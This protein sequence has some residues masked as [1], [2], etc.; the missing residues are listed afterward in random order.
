MWWGYKSIGFSTETIVQTSPC[1][2]LRADI[3]VQ[4]RAGVAFLEATGPTWLQGDL[5]G[6]IRLRLSFYHMERSILVHLRMLLRPDYPQHSVFANGLHVVASFAPIVRWLCERHRDCCT[7]EVFVVNLETKDT[8]TSV[9]VHMPSPVCR[10]V[11]RQEVL[12]ACP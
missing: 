11:R 2:H 7:L 10:Y 12:V 1:R 5:M 6:V 9:A 3:S 4:P 8:F